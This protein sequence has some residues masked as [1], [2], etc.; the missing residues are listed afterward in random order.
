MALLRY[1]LHLHEYRIGGSR[2]G[3]DQPS[4]SVVGSHQEFAR[5]GE[6]G[7]RPRRDKEDQN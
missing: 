2:I 6:Q 4:E 5:P 7:D 1:E 3:E